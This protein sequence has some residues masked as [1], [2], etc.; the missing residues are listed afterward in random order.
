MYFKDG[1]LGLGS[2]PW[3]NRALTIDRAPD[4]VT[5]DE[6]HYGI[7]ARVITSS[8]DGYIYGAKFSVQGGSLNAGLQV[9]AYS[10]SYS[11]A[12]QFNSDNIGLLVTAPMAASLNGNVSI[13]GSLSKSS[14]SFKIDH[15]LDPENKYLFHS[16]VESPDMMNVYNGNITLDAHGRAIVKM[17]DYFEALNRDFR[18]Q[19][20]AIGAPAPN[21]YIESE[22]AGNRFVIAGGQANAK[23]S[24]Q[25]T[26]IRHDP[27]AD[28]H[29]IEVEVDKPDSEKGY[30]MVPELYGLGEDKKIDHEHGLIS[31]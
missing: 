10:S 14:G 27:W 24:W 3:T 22:I 1:D 7:H 26:G 19:L 11:I 21:L 4:P 2:T 12:G 30:Y 9:T 8:T 23:V 13:V 5:A 20:T 6:Q 29:R 31:D 28:E 18:Y 15:P 25:V 16:F 17:P